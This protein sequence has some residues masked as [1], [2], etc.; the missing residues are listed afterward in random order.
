MDQ[1]EDKLAFVS[2]LIARSDLVRVLPDLESLI[3]KNADKTARASKPPGL[4][5]RK[6]LPGEAETRRGLRFVERFAHLFSW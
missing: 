2:C 5:S 3:E 1:D 6:V 4:A